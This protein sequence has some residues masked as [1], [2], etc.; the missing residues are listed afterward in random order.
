MM[1]PI[2]R[3]AVAQRNASQRSGSVINWSLPLKGIH[4]RA[5]RSELVGT[6]AHVLRNWRPTGV[7]LEMRQGYEVEVRDTEV[8]QRIPFEFGTNPRYVTIRRHE[9]L[10]GDSRVNHIHSRHMSWAAISSG[11]I[12]V[13]GTS[14]QVWRVDEKGISD[15]AFTTDS[16]KDPTEFTG[17][18]AHHDRLYF[19]DRRELSFYYAKEVGGIMGDLVRFPLDRLG[20][21]TGTVAFISSMTVNAARTISDVLVIGTTS[22]EIIMYEGLDPG[23]AQGWSLLGR[24]ATKARPVAAAGIENFGSDLWVLTSRGIV[25]VRDSLAQGAMALAQSV[26]RPISDMLVDLVQ[27]YGDVDGWQMSMLSEK[28]DLVVSVPS[29]QPQQY[30]FSIESQAWWTADYP[31]T[32]FHELGGQASF[33]RTDGALCVLGDDLDDG[34]PITA[35]I[36]SGWVRVGGVQTLSYFLPT[37]LARGALTIEVGVLTDHNETDDDIAQ[38][39]Q[40]VTIAP[41]KP[42]GIVALNQ[43]IPVGATGRVFQMRWTVIGGGVSFENLQAGAV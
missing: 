15:A 43:T 25:S 24:I 39:M 14:Q 22:G 16:G 17:A 2:G 30:I 18:F 35:P 33:T 26:A 10:F 13:D 29:P 27:Q 38:A 40:R 1:T 5:E 19:W 11:L 36:V 9:I 8:K 21:I 4:S 42:G 37:L 7:S 20:N 34:K 12:L 31:A 3:A 28:I 6:L 41:S 32:E 23:D